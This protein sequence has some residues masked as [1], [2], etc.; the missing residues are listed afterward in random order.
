VYLRIPQTTPGRGLLFCILLLCSTTI[1][2]QSGYVHRLEVAYR[3]EY[4][5][6]THRFLSSSNAAQQSIRWGESPHLRYAFRFRPHSPLARLY[7][8]A[9][10][11]IGIGYFHFG[12]SR[13]LGNPLSIYLFQG[14]R[15][16]RLSSKLTLNYEWNLGLSLGWKPYDKERNPNN[17]VIGSKVNAYLHAGVHLEWT[18]SP[19]FDLIVGLAATHFSN[20]NTK[21]PNAGL[22]TAGLRV[23]TAYYFNRTTANQVAANT[24]AP[25]VPLF[26]PHIS[27]DLTLFGSWRK[28]GVHVDDSY[29]ASPKSYAVVGFNFAPMYTV[30]RRFRA[31]L[32]LDGVFDSSSNVYATPT[33][34]ENGVDGFTTHAPA[35]N[36]QL[37]LGISARA[38]YVMPYFTIGAGL[39]ANLWHGGGAHKGVYQVLTLKMELS[40]NTYLHVGYNLKEFHTPNY[41][42]LGLGIRLHNKNHWR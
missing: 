3:Q 11:G 28:T 5:F 36:K 35:L 16:A 39:G 10:Q 13:E 31:G 40:R 30:C 25:G 14:A 42:M 34:D 8:D 17:Y 21:Y 6:P 37:A 26:T 19:R 27:Y 38:E 41:L 24:S 32:S 12:N 1:Y 9:Y 33:Q 20:G 18:V 2:S 23:G 29:V 15:L 22:N 7:A 4:I